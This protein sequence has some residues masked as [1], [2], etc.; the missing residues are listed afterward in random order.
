MCLS[1]TWPV[2][3]YCIGADPFDTSPSSTA[4][5]KQLKETGFKLS[6]IKVIDKIV[7]VPSNSHL[8]CFGASVFSEISSGRSLVDFRGQL[9]SYGT[10]LVF[11]TFA[12]GY[13]YRKP[14][15]MPLFKQDLETFR[16]FIDFD[17]KGATL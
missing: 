11:P 7:D 1:G 8:L 12:P 14:E 15:L 9:F 3:I 17:Q 10:T 13:L 2:V 16:V 4:L 5:H 6:E